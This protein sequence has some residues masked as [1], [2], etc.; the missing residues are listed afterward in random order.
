MTVPE[1]L[2]PVCNIEALYGVIRAGA[3]A[4]Y[5]GGKRFGARAYAGNLSDEELVHAITYTRLHGKRLYLTVNTLIK[6]KELPELEAFLRPL[7]EAG[8]DGVIVQDMGVVRLVRECFPEVEIHASTQMAV[9]DPAGARLLMERG[10]KRVVPARELSLEELA[11]IRE[12]GA[13]VEAFIH[14]AM[15]YSYSGLCLMSSMLGGRSGNRGRCAQAC[16][17]PYRTR[18]A[19]QNTKE[20]GNRALSRRD[21]GEYPLSMK[22]MCLAGMLPALI[23]AG[24]S[25]LKIEGRM[26]APEYAAGVTGIYREL[27]DQAIQSPHPDPE[28]IQ[29]AVKR[30]SA[31]YLR[32]EVGTGYLSVRNGREMITASSPAYTGSDREVLT[33]IRERLLTGPQKLPVKMRIRLRAGEKACLRVQMG[34]PSGTVATEEYS[35]ESCQQ[36]RN[37]AMTADDIRSHLVKLGDT[38]FEAEECEVDIGDEPLFIPVSILNELRRRAMDRLLEETAGHTHSADLQK[39]TAFRETEKAAALQDTDHTGQTMSLYATI[40]DKEQL[41]VFME[42]SEEERLTVYRG[43]YLETGLMLSLTDDQKERLQGTGRIYLALPYILRE[44]SRGIGLCAEDIIKCIRL[45]RSIITGVVVRTPGELELVRNL[46]ASETENGQYREFDT[47]IDYSLYTWNSKAVAEYGDIIQNTATVRWSLPLELSFR[48]QREMIKSCDGEFQI[49]VY[50]RVPVMLTANCIRR[51]AGRCSGKTGSTKGYT[52]ACDTEY[53]I[54][55]KKMRWPVTT[56][57]RN[58]MNIIWNSVPVSLHGQMEK[59]TGIREITGMRVDLSTEGADE[60]RKVLLYWE[61]LAE[62]FSSGQIHPAA[63]NADPDTDQP[64]YGNYTTGHFRQG[65]E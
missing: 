62:K 30:L 13:E 38:L 47:V 7:A 14:G 10:I 22:D 46:N 5:L 4:V 19:G 23:Q 28:I 34:L 52:A 32:S 3:D 44:D 40:R 39:R 25:S 58:C 36:A 49:M 37:R 12:T 9:T 21:V 61:K 18:D 6:E 57:C 51:T 33:D 35:A 41:D 24:I 54:D 55:R 11:A 43:I 50:G 63:V 31:I 59:V 60:S 16:R 1:L 42:L 8:L 45:N 53:L 29:S 2:S 15:C 64:P 48:E 27:I 65:A 17:L 20:P 26:K 56:D